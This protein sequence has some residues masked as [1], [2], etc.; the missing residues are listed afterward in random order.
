M[1]EELSKWA[2]D[3]AA[4]MCVSPDREHLPW[5]QYSPSE[6]QCILR[7]GDDAQ[8]RVDSEFGVDTVDPPVARYH[9]RSQGGQ[10]LGTLTYANGAVNFCVNRAETPNCGPVGYGRDGLDAARKMLHVMGMQTDEA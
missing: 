1:A 3:W 7:V 8:G 6:Q 9:V 2:R 5:D 4:S 10:D